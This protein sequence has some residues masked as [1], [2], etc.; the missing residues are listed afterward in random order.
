MNKKVII[1]ILMVVM[2]F[3]SGFAGENEFSEGSLFL[4][5][6]IALYKYA[7]NFGAS[8]EYGLTENIGIGASLML[9]FWSDNLGMNGKASQTLITPSVEGY[10][11]FTKLDAKKLDVFA[12]A[13]LGYSI[14]SWSWDGP[15]GS[16]SDAGSS[17]IYLSPFVGCRYYFNK[18]IAAYLNLHFSV[19]GDRSGVGGVVGVTFRLK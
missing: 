7:P 12:G 19:L 14:Y 18:K 13:S 5:P 11:H 6:Q 4:T 9:A 10:Y 15:G 1:G 2:F 17:D 8:L 3:L 16:W